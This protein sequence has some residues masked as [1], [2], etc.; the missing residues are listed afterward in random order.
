MVLNVDGQLVSCGQLYD[1]GVE[2]H[3]IGILPAVIRD[4]KIGAREASGP[5]ILDGT[6]VP[7]VTLSVPVDKLWKKLPNSS[8]DRQTRKLAKELDIKAWQAAGQQS[9]LPFRK[10]LREQH[11]AILIRKE[12]VCC[13]KSKAMRRTFTLGLCSPDTD[14][15]ILGLKPVPV[16]FCYKDNNIGSIDSLLGKRWDVLQKADG[17]F[18]YVTAVR[19]WMT[20]L[21][22]INGSVRVGHARCQFSDDYRVIV[23]RLIATAGLREEDDEEE[24][25]EEEDIY[26]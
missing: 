10:A 19:L 24:E 20:N 15:A 4:G 11:L 13:L 26:L 14:V 7:N 16:R 1:I 18:S 6:L 22:T 2:S 3:T 9:S 21:R 25:D 5:L 17:Q 8:L 23:K 12:I